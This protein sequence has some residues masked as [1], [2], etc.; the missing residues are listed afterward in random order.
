[1]DKLIRSSEWDNN[2]VLL[3]TLFTVHLK[4]RLSA[5]RVGGV[6]EEGPQVGAYEP[7]LLSMVIPL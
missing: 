6:G 3:P 2:L 5:V 7:F 4:K 1:M